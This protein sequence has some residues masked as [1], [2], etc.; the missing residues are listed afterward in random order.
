MGIV[1]GITRCIII[2]MGYMYVGIWHCLKNH[3]CHGI[4]YHQI[5]NFCNKKKRVTSV[6]AHKVLCEEL[7]MFPII[8]VCVLGYLWF[9]TASLALFL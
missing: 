6:I 3:L 5:E 7:Q 4:G 1:M 9:D 8:C 2:P